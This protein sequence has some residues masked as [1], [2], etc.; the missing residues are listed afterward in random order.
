M[1]IL[2]ILN[3]TA[4]LFLRYVT[5][6]FYAWK[7]KREVADNSRRLQMRIVLVHTARRILISRG[8]C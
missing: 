4:L 7:F 2:Q 1:F 5:V 8:S 3:I 6:S